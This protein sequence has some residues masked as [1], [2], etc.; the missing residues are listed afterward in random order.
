MSEQKQQL[1]ILL[2]ALK[3]A[4][5]GITSAMEEEVITPEQVYYLLMSLINQLESILMSSQEEV[6]MS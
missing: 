5:S 2:H 6:L 1:E 4:A 3:G